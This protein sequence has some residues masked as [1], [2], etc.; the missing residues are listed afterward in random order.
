M[1]GGVADFDF[2]A[3]NDPMDQVRAE[4]K[5]TAIPHDAAEESAGPTSGR[6]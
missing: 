2:R 4:P 5:A 1:S 3:Y 6:R